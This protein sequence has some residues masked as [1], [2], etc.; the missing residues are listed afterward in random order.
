MAAA[1]VNQM[2]SS[3]SA[4]VMSRRPM[5][6][7]LEYMADGDVTECDA[8]RDEDPAAGRSGREDARKCGGAH[9]RPETRFKRS[10][11]NYK[12]L[13]PMVFLKPDQGTIAA[14]DR[15]IESG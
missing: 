10:R 5:E 9:P 2:T 13:I 1:M 6:Y 4:E 11:P 15:A 14:P 7:G 8:R 12:R 3:N